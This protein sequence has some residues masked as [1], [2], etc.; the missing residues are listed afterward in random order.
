MGAMETLYKE[1]MPSADMRQ[2]MANA[3]KAGTLGKPL[4]ERGCRYWPPCV[5]GQGPGYRHSG[6]KG[7]APSRPW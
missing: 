4:K 5:H 1:A 3:G 2:A 6:D 7:P